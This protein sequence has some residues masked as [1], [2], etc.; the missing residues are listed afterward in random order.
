MLAVLGHALGSAVIVLV[1]VFGIWQF[2]GNIVLTRCLYKVS[3]ESN[4]AA[5][6]LRVSYFFDGLVP[7]LAAS[8]SGWLFNLSGLWLIWFVLLIEVCIQQAQGSIQVSSNL[9]LGF[10]WS[11]TGGL[12]GLLPLIPAMAS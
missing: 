4:A 12:I 11:T 9:W 5:I 7:A 8:L 10:R 6:L 2:T 1:C 3:L